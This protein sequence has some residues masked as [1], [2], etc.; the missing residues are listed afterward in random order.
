M[1]VA[2]VPVA[3]SFTAATAAATALFMFVTR[4]SPPGA[5]A[6]VAISGAAHT[7][8]QEATRTSGHSTIAANT[9]IARTTTTAAAIP[10]PR[11]KAVFAFVRVAFSGYV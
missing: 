2:V 10:A 4:R 5:S 9:I 11:A 3:I 1:A 6:Q 7:R 8:A